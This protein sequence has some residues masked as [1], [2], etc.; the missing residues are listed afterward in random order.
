MTTR[1]ELETRR[2]PL[3]SILRSVADEVFSHPG[4]AVFTPSGP[5]CLPVGLRLLPQ[6]PEACDRYHIRTQRHRDAASPE[7][8]HRRRAR[9]LASRRRAG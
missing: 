9:R 8:R 7:R 6:P 4:L 3:H 2:R 5:G 1:D